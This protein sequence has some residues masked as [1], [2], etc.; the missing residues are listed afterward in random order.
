[1]ASKPALVPGD[2]PVTAMRIRVDTAGFRPSAF[3]V[4]AGKPVVLTL[5]NEDNPFRSGGGGYHRFVIESLGVRKVLE[6]LSTQTFQLVLMEPGRYEFS[7]DVGH[8]GM[9]GAA[10]RGVLMAE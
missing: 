5:A 2:A 1:M 10:M 6:P 3:R 9:P 4:R 7:C 8:G